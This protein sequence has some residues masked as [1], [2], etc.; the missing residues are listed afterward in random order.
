MPTSRTQLTIDIEL[1]SEPI[2]GS[3][4]RADGSSTPF[5]GWIALVSLLQDAATTRARQGD[6]PRALAV[7]ARREEGT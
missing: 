2:A 3:L 7:A 1:D 4:G 6:Q 5:T